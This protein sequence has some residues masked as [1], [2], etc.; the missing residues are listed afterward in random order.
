[1]RIG[2]ALLAAFGMAGCSGDGSVYVEGNGIPAAP[3]DKWVRQAPPPQPGDDARRAV[4]LREYPSAPIRFD[5]ME[6]KAIVADAPEKRAAGLAFI[7]M[8][9]MEGAGMLFVMPNE[10]PQLKLENLEFDVDVV[11]A[12]AS[13]RVLSLEVVDAPGGSVG[14]GSAA[15]YIFVLPRGRAKRLKIV[16]GQSIGMS[17]GTMSTAGVG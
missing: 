13:K 16:P 5:Q 3:R 7:P 1:M 11:L 15:K 2:W 8:E 14:A 10:D 12:D 9:K 17:G 6:V 4:Q